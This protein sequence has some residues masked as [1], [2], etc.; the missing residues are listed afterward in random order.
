M[1]RYILTAWFTCEPGVEILTGDDSE[2][3]MFH[4]WGWDAWMMVDTQTGVVTF[5]SDTTKN[6]VEIITELL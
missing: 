4:H 5:D 2:E 3:L 6:Q 1:K